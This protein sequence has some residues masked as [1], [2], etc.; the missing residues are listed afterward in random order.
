MRTTTPCDCPIPEQVLEIGT[1]LGCQA[2][3]IDTYNKLGDNLFDYCDT[4][5]L[6]SLCTRARELGVKTVLA[7]SIDVDCLRE[8][9][10]CQPDLIGVRAQYASGIANQVFANPNSSTLELYLIRFKNQGLLIMVAQKTQKRT[11]PLNQMDKFCIRSAYPEKRFRL[12]K[13]NFNF[14]IHSSTELCYSSESR[15][16][17]A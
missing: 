16:R 10:S 11:T 8:A 3:L 15:L 9:V 1:E 7:G 5:R 12:E 13:L 4:A 6:T 14:L 2:F 17:G